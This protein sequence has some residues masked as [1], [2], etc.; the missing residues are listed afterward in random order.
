MDTDTIGI[1]YFI[2]F[3]ITAFGLFNDSI[4]CLNDVTLNVIVV[5]LTGSIIWPIVWVYRI[6]GSYKLLKKIG[7]LI[8]IMNLCIIG[9]GMFLMCLQLTEPY[10]IQPLSRFW[11]L[12][13]GL[14][15][16][17]LNISIKSFDM[18]LCMK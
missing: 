18:N 1:L 4:E 10:F 5:V 13:I 8:L 11:C 17:V 6:I 3:L 12:F 9:F 15:I 7:Y 2:F 16:K 14:Q